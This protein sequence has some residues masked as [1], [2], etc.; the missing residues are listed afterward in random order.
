M[1]GYNYNEFSEFSQNDD[2]YGSSSYIRNCD[3]K[4]KNNAKNLHNYIF[5]KNS[6]QMDVTKKYDIYRHKNIEI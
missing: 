3:I 5:P 4:E 6:N 2:L 1:L